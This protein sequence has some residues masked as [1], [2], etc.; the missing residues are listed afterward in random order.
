MSQPQLPG[1]RVRTWHG[2]CLWIR[3]MLIH[4]RHCITTRFFENGIWSSIPGFTQPIGFFLSNPVFLTIFSP[5]SAQSCLVHVHIYSKMWRKGLHSLSSS[6]SV[7]LHQSLC[8]NSS[9][10]FLPSSS[11]RRLKSWKHHLHFHSLFPGSARPMEFP[12]S[13]AFISSRACS[14]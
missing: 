14:R 4:A 5:P 6:S 13:L 1:G 11:E 9:S 2:I 3:L 12:L 8:A 7:C 10:F